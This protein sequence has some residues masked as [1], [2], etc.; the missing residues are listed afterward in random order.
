[1]KYGERRARDAF[2]RGGRDLK[3]IPA[4]S[5]AMVLGVHTFRAAVKTGGD[6][7]G[8]RWR[9]CGKGEGGGRPRRRVPKKPLSETRWPRGDGED[10]DCC[11]W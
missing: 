10:E 1:L 8:V 3:T 2:R 7:G 4:G 5:G 9:R 11:W 6:N